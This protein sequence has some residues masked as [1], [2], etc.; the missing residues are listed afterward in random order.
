MR[1]GSQ[2]DS[3]SRNSVYKLGA[4]LAKQLKNNW[5]PYCIHPAIDVNNKPAN[6][7]INDRSFGSDKNLVTLMGICTYER[8][9]R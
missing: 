7:I 9:A 2:C 3:R 4:E 5:Y 6:P 1:Y 8:I